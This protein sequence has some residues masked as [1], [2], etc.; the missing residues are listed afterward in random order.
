MTETAND[1]H[2]RVVAEILDEIFELDTSGSEAEGGFGSEREAVE[3]TWNEYLTPEQMVAE[4]KQ[5][6]GIIEGF[7]VAAED[8]SPVLVTLL[9]DTQKRARRALE[10]AEPP[11][12]RCI[13]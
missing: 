10:I 5:A 8:I 9:S 6:A 12:L 2:A 4:L 11:H 3:V 13:K 7:L 1:S